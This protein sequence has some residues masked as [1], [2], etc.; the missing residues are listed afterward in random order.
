[1][2]ELDLGGRMDVPVLNDRR[3]VVSGGDVRGRRPVGEVHATR[4]TI[5]A[6]TVARVA[7]CLTWFGLRPVTVADQLSNDSSC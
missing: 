3:A 2:V 5:I 6:T 1:M 4:P 7:S